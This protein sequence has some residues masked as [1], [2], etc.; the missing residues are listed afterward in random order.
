[1]EVRVGEKKERKVSNPK[2]KLIVV[3]VVVCSLTKRVRSRMKKRQPILWTERP[4][5]AVTTGA[6]G[7][8]WPSVWATMEM[9]GCNNS[10]W[11]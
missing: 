5:G 3:V 1:M 6:T 4:T 9:S 8:L 11:G 2:K 7:S 10:Q